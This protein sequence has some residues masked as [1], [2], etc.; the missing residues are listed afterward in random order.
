MYTQCIREDRKKRHSILKSLLGLYDQ[1]RA[2]DVNQWLCT[3]QERKDQTKT[4]KAQL[5]SYR[6]SSKRVCSD[7]SAYGSDK[8]SSGTF[9]NL[10]FLAFIATTL[11]QLPYDVQEEPLFI[12]HHISR[13]V[14]YEGSALVEHFRSLLAACHVNVVES[15]EDEIHSDV[16]DEKPLLLSPA[17]K[18]E[19]TANAS[20]SSN[21]SFLGDGRDGRLLELRRA[22]IDS[23]AVCMLLRIKHYLKYVYK[24]ANGKCQDYSPSEST[25]VDELSP[26]NEFS[27][28]FTILVRDIMFVVIFPCC[29]ISG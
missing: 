4:M 11:C 8:S 12:I 6:S 13:F 19:Q 29:A 5:V 22:C 24:F 14:S 27:A 9:L 10:E 20:A 25:K 7:S 28:R 23:V 3:L 17:K 16:A 1:K 15:D 26:L 2:S 18:N 21:S